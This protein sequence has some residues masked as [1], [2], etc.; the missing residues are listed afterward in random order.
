VVPSICFVNDVGNIKL[1][2]L[3]QN[4]WELVT[5][6]SVALGRSGCSS[7]N[8]G[9]PAHSMIFKEGGI[10]VLR[11]IL[12]A[13]S[14]FTY[15]SE[16]YGILIIDKSAGEPTSTDLAQAK[17]AAQAQAKEADR[18]AAEAAAAEAAKKKKTTIIC[19][20]GKLT[21]KVTAVKPVCPKGYK[22]KKP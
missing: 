5:Q 15:V 16:P 19:V 13:D 17:A 4:K 3:N 6:G 22:K 20:K 10:K 1:E 21:K 12:P 2:I 8:Y 18:L 7:S 14:K 11:W 9:T